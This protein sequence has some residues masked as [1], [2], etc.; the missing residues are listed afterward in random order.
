MSV[1]R[2]VAM[3]DERNLWVSEDYRMSDPRTNV[4]PT[5][6]KLFPQGY[7]PGRPKCILGLGNW[8]ELTTRDFFQRHNVKMVIKA[9]GY[10]PRLRIQKPPYYGACL[11]KPKWE[12][13]YRDLPSNATKVL[14]R[15]WEEV[16]HTAI[17]TWARGTLHKP[18]VVFI[19]CNGGVNRAA[20]LAIMLAST[21]RLQLLGTGQVL[22]GGAQNQPDMGGRRAGE[23]V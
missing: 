11:S 15:D 19:H 5:F 14:Q 21:S 16:L 20:F 2:A 3:H 9:S 6:L 13:V 12:F 4:P 22:G 8:L 17:E 7:E 10:N 1:R 23:Q 18:A